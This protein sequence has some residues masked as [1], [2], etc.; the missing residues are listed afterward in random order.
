MNPMLLYRR[1]QRPICPC[2]MTGTV[3]TVS[4][5]RA[6]ELDQLCFDTRV[7]LLIFSY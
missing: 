4:A 3:K 6:C 7:E 5:L 2:D 1:H